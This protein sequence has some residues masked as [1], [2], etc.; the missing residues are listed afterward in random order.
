MR[1]LTGGA[2]LTVSALA[3]LGC[4]LLLRRVVHCL[5]RSEP[6][7]TLHDLG[8]RE[9]TP[10]GK[11]QRLLQWLRGSA[12][13]DAVVVLRTANPHDAALY[14]SLLLPLQKQLNFS[15]ALVT[16]AV[17]GLDAVIIIELRTREFHSKYTQAAAAAAAP[18]AVPTNIP[19]PSSAATAAAAVSSFKAQ[20]CLVLCCVQLPDL[21][22]YRELPAFISR[23]LAA[24]VNN[25]RLFSSYAEELLFYL[26]FIEARSRCHHHHHQ[27]H[28]TATTTLATPL[29][30][31]VSSTQR[32]HKHIFSERESFMSAEFAGS[33]STALSCG[34]VD[35]D[36]SLPLLGEV[37]DVNA[38]LFST[39]W[40]VEVDDRA[41]SSADDAVAFNSQGEDQ[42]IYDA[43]HEAFFHVV[44]HTPLAR[45]DFFA[46]DTLKMHAFK[47]WRASRRSRRAAA[48]LY[49]LDVAAAKGDAVISFAR[50]VD[51]VVAQAVLV[52]HHGSLVEFVDALFSRFS[53]RYTPV[54]T[55]LREVV[56]RWRAKVQ[57]RQQ[58]DENG[59]GDAW[60][61]GRGTASMDDD[62]HHTPPNVGVCG[63]T[64]SME[65]GMDD[66]EDDINDVI[67]ELRYTREYILEH[68]ITFYNAM[69]TTQGSNQLEEVFGVP[70]TVFPFL[71]CAR[72]SVAFVTHAYD[73]IVAEYG[74]LDFHNFTKYAHDVFVRDRP[75]IVR[76]APRIFRM[77]NKTRSGIISF[78]ELCC[79]MA[80]KLSSGSRLRPD[81][82][83]IAI[84]MSLRLP[85]ALLLN[86]RHQWSRMECALAS[87]SDAD[88]DGY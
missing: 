67:R 60:M 57:R 8:C 71:P 22:V 88:V 28:H 11:L 81:S 47:V 85:L 30:S 45:P 4:V 75:E 25:R 66:C 40:L 13:A 5:W 73:C 80:R 53:L 83:L 15:F 32:E 31:T 1:R 62:S 26:P 68:R 9:R 56:E 7:T 20:E 55:A 82:H 87:L 86:K 6:S 34:G 84:A 74:P 37:I 52:H 63:R 23:L 2:S 76:H 38:T 61:A 33:V 27:N 18:F 51:E 17:V 21:R 19:P 16:E 36:A 10:T 49:V 48:E 70:A 39:S 77:L 44:L 64:L 50:V 58:L 69:L 35:E 78:E 72:E 59:E 46:A 24:H 65:D 12:C 3:T 29:S 41:A 42:F 79:W 54:T 14:H 43:I